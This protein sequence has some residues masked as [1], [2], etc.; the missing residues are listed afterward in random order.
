MSQAPSF[1][2]EHLSLPPFSQNLL[3][4]PNSDAS[5]A[6]VEQY[7]AKV[8]QYGT[9]L[10]EYKK[11]KEAVLEERRKAVEEWQAKVA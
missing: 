9:T 4:N 3:S 6:E 8:E 1:Q 7:E 10:A 2:S 5:T 11:A